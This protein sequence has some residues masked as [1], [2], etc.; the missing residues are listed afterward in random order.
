MAMS[1]EDQ[2]AAAERI[3]TREPLTD[4][5]VENLKYLTME[6]EDYPELSPDKLAVLE[7]LK[8]E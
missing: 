8:R 4:E 1:K 5:E 3:L 2:R 6:I 7:K